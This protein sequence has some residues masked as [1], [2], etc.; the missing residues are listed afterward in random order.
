LPPYQRT[1]A[2]AE[3]LPTLAHR[4]DIQHPLHVECRDPVLTGGYGLAP[5]IARQNAE[6]C[7][8]ERRGTDLVRSR[9]QPIRRFRVALGWKGA[10]PHSGPIGPP[11]W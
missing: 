4:C 6:H 3:S 8:S 5:T 10:T 7:R 1:P 9:Q 11:G 2:P